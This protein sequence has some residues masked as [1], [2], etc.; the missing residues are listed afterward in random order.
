MNDKK[1]FSV[2]AIYF[3]N[4]LYIYRPKLFVGLLMM[5]VHY[6]TQY[7]TLQYST[8]DSYI[9]PRIELLIFGSF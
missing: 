2:S 8:P 1:Y 6:S 7:S 3:L 4:F 9:S 5:T